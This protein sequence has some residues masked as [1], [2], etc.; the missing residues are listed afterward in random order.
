MVGHASVLVG[1]K[2]AG[3][4]NMFYGKDLLVVELH[5]Q[6]EFTPEWELLSQSLGHRYAGYGCEPMRGSSRPRWFSYESELLQ[7]Y[8]HRDR[9]IRVDVEGF[10]RVLSEQLSNPIDR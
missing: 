1:Q 6:V 3:L 10:V 4:T 2:G 5:N 8:P 9:D 7:E